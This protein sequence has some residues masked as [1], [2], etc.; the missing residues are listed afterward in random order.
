M[1]EAVIEAQAVEAPV[2]AIE[3]VRA[4]TYLVFD[5]ETSGLFNFKLPADDPSQPRLAS[6]AFI[7]CDETGT[8]IERQK[9]Y[10]KPDGWSID[11]TDA[12]KI[13]GLTDAF[14]TENGVPVGDVL[15]AYTRHIEA[16]LI[17]VAFNAQFDCKMMRSE[18]RRAN[19]PDLFEQ[20]RNICVMRSCDAYARDGLCMTRPGFVKLATACD[21][22]GIVNEN[23]HDAMA[24]AVAA[25]VILA[26]MIA[27]DRLPEAKVHLAKVR[28]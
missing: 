3:P 9:F 8:E 11:G 6:A 18:L 2:A 22:F 27:D 5:T 19:R 4:P 25:Q 17:A 26:R 12:G 14:L 15:D 24:D 20:T 1:N 28:D 21:F 16:G 13:N 7:I 10:V 23:A